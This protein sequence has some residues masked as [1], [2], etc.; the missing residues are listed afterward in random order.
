MP[1]GLDR[2]Q[3]RFPISEH[4][5]HPSQGPGCPAIQFNQE[6]MQEVGPL[7]STFDFPCLAM[8]TA[9]EQLPGWSRHVPSV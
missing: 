4:T 5:T 3:H 9:L 1:E 2:E 7:T 8:I 6:E